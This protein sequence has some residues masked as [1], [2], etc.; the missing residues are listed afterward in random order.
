M[1]KI[2]FFFGM[3]FEENLAK[4]SVKVLACK[5]GHLISWNVFLIIHFDT[6]SKAGTYL[7]D[8]STKLFWL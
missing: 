5:I 1:Q 4:T 3:K 8:H 7:F 6:F 2:N